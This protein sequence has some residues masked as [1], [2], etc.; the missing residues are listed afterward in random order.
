[1]NKRKTQESWNENYVCTLL[2]KNLHHIHLNLL[3]NNSTYSINFKTNEHIK[4]RSNE[5]Q[6]NNPQM[7]I[8][9]RLEMSKMRLFPPTLM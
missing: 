5:H 2:N 9:Y 3:Y 6:T 1:M 7:G 8:Q 4:I